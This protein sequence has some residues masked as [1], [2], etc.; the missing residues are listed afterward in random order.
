MEREAPPE[1]YFARQPRSASAE[2]EVVYHFGGRRFV[3]RTDAGV[4]SPR[5]I[6]RGTALL[7]AR[8]PLPMEGEILD[9]GAG[10]GAIGVVVAAF[11]LTARVLLVEINE[12]AAA[13]AAR[14]AEANGVSN[15][16][17]TAG[18]AFEVLG[19]RQFDAVLTNPPIHA[20]KQ[21]VL[22]LIRQSSEHLLP[23]GELWM[24]ARTQDGARSYLALMH[25]CFAQAE[26]V[27]MRGGYRVLRASSPPEEP[28]PNARPSV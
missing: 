1:H 8:L 22:S 19:G 18:D 14:N 15:A 28:V 3:F 2:R 6:D 25:E 26:R 24:V 27:A 10:Y 23:G 21:T 9:W 17:V 20:G 5:G 4:F 11:S 12:R 7:L 13:L 16:G